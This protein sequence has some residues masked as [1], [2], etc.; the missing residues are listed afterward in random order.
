MASEL[1]TVPALATRRDE[2]QSWLQR[3]VSKG[4]GWARKYSL[5]Q[6]PFVT[7][8]CGMEYMSLQIGALRPRPLRRGG[9]PASRRARPTCSWWSAPST[10]SRRP[11]SGAIYEQMAEPKWVM[12]FGVCASSGG[13]YDNYATVQGIDRIIPVDVYVPGCPPRPEQVLDGIMLL[14]KKI[15]DQPHKLIDR[16]ALPLLPDVRGD[17]LARTSMSKAV[18][19]A[20]VERFPDAVYDPYVGVGGDD[21]AFVTKEPDRRGLPVPQVGALASTWRRTSPRSTTSGR[22]PRF[23]VVYNLFST[24]TNERIR[25][26]VKVPESDCVVPTVTGVWR[27]ADWFERYCWDMYGIRFDG[28][29]DPRRLLLYEEFVGHPL[30]KDYPLRG[31]QPLVPE[32]EI[33]DL[34]RG[35]GARHARLRRLGSDSEWPADTNGHG[36]APA[37]KVVVPAQ[38]SPLDAPLPAQADGRSTSG[39]RTRPCTASTQ[40]RR[41]ARRR[42]DHRPEVEIG[43]LHRGFEKS[44]ENVTWTQVFPYT[45]RLNYVSLDPQQRRV[46]A[47]GRE[48]LQAR[49][50]GAREVPARHHLRAAPHLR[51]PDPRRRDRPRARRDDDRPLRR[52]G[53]R[54]RLRPAHRALRRAPHLELRAASAASPATSPRAGSRRRSRPSTASRRCARRS[55]ALLTRNRIFLDRTRGRRRHLRARTPSTTG[56]PGRAC[57]RPATPTTSARPL[58]TS[59][60]TGSTSTSRWARTATTSTATS[61]ASRRC[62]SPTGSSASASQQM[63]PGRDHRR[64]L[65]FVLPPKPHV[66]RTIEGVM[67]H[68]KL[69]MEGI[70]VPAGEAY[71][72]TEAATA[73]SASTSCPTAAAGPTS[74]PA[75][76][77]LADAR[78]AAAHDQGRAARR[79]RPDLRQHQHDRR[80]GRAVAPPHPRSRSETAMARRDQARRRPR[81]RPQSRAGPPAPPPPKNPGFVT[82]TIDGTRGRREARHDRHRG[83]E[84]VGVEIPYYCY[85]KRLSIAA[86]CR[87]CLVEMSNAPMGKLMP[88]CQMPV[89]EGMTVKTDT[90]AREATSSARCSSSC[91]STTR[92]TAPSATRPASASCRTT[93]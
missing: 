53:A 22:T 82:A 48:A 24:R 89:A 1:D 19:D 79:P 26:R 39:R 8:C 81:P 25:L 44:C 31:R 68:F 32:R 80:R 38:P 71:S 15:Q 72:Y 73:S 34:F 83:G 47:G 90:P 23:E 93:T 3:I 66:Y 64:R 51:P 63:E 33:N 75:R 12:A 6:Y 29:P 35:P 41:R 4:V 45:D 27:G 56:S 49:R 61:C 67:A 69:I 16:Q 76:A 9:C 84:A 60:T 21:C 20:L 46:R 50:P 91:C 40:F 88:G 30:R 62:A 54:P 7:A 57:A 92:S 17:A 87:M 11:S 52:R 18:I 77:G 37:A 43:F 36:T 2:A 86:N 74:R 70:K 65:R 78:R 59:S 10:A 58:P 13:F 5:F 85:H 28:H 42:D 14:Q 55:T